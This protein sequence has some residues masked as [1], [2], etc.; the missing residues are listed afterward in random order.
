[1][2][3]KVYFAGVFITYT[4]WLFLLS[5]AVQC[6]FALYFF[7]RI[8]T[9]PPKTHTLNHKDLGITPSQKVSIIIC[10][11]NEASHLQ[12]NL[13]A[14]LAQRY[15]NDAG[16]PQYEV[17]VV[18][19]ASTDD[20][21]N[22][23]QFFQ[24]QHGHLKVVNIPTGLPRE[25]PGKKFALSKG[26]EAAN[27][28]WLV[29]TD[30]DCSPASD[31]WLQNMIAP[32]CQGKQIVAGYGGFQ[33]AK[34]FLNTFIRWE[35]MHTFL[36]YST[37][38][39][40]GTPYMAV[41]RNMACT[42]TILQQAQ[43]TDIWAL[44]PSGDDDMLMRTMATAENTAIVYNPASFTLSHAKSNW[45]AWKLQKQRHLSTGKYY[46]TYIKLALGKYALFHA[47]MWLAFLA[48]LFTPFRVIVA[49]IMLGRCLMYWGLW[50]F[51]L[52]RLQEKKILLYLPFC[53]IGWALYNFIFA[54]YIIW[55]N[56]QQ[57]K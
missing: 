28:K 10:A 55:K 2:S 42:K 47:L 32:L 36:Q 34:G 23:L 27:N 25:L 11:K 26:L 8:F 57:W 56:K 52:Q 29:L 43:R 44:L 39:W 46:R 20:S 24:Q 35:T 4:Y 5:I 38:T 6:G 51:T 50:A 1:M 30:A 54:P 33:K 22:I 7:F 3:E 17:I 49:A 48:L 15:T 12:T 16:I 45:Q 13:P 18:N 53:D 9:H 31:E 37:Y 40:A 41:G 19:D 14:I 21:A